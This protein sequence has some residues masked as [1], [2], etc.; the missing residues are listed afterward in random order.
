MT[1][2]SGTGQEKGLAGWVARI[3]ENLAG[4]LYLGN[5]LLVVARRP[6]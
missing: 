1:T 3:K 5:A 6:V 2:A 4:V